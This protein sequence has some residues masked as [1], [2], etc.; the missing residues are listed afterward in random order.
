MTAI[1]L[2]FNHGRQ[3]KKHMGRKGKK[4]LH[5]SIA[6]FPEAQGTM[7]PLRRLLQTAEPLPFSQANARRKFILLYL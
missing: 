7:H 3:R 5:L 6:G 1:K 2:S 4:D